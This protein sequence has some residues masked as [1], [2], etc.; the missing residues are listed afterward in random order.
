MFKR[1]SSVTLV[2]FKRYSGVALVML[3]GDVAAL[4]FTAANGTPFSPPFV[5][6]RSSAELALF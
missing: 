3:S 1:C 4:L 6:R 2:L 5:W